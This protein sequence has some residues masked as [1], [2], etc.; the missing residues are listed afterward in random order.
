M[1][2]ASGKKKNSNEVSSSPSKDQ[3]EYLEIHYKSLGSIL[4]LKQTLFYIN[5][6]F[7]FYN[8]KSEKY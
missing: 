1:C 4:W 3:L 2:K 7:Y 8:D 6:Y 5:W